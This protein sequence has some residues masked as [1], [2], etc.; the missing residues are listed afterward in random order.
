MKLLKIMCAALMAISLSAC[1]S[2]EAP[3][4]KKQAEPI[5][6]LSPMGA[7][8]LSLLGLYVNSDVTIDTVDGSD[9]LSAEFSKED[10]YDIIVAPINL[11]AKLISSGKSPYQL[12][13]VVTWGNLYIVGTDE[14]ALEKE[15]AFAA[16]GEAAVPQKVLTSSMDMKEI[17]PTITYYNSVNDVQAQLLSGKA[18]VGLLAEPAASATI[19]KAKEKGIELKVITDLQKAYKEK[20]KKTNDGYPQA[21]IFVRKDRIKNSSTYIETAKEFV[22]SSSEDEKE[23]K[24]AIDVATIDKLGVPSVDM[25]LKT[26]KRQNINFVKASKVKEDITS[27]LKQFDITLKDEYYTE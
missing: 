17:K 1:A 10:G 8:A 6:I 13:S 12:D 11:G 21:A 4:E 19:A 14:K 7:T 2:K 23:M 22:D 15:G 5:K 18:N 3:K 16:F 27:F 20:N 25:I 9:A 24:N 26:W